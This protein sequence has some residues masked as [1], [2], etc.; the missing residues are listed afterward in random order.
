MT[1]REHKMEVI[2]SLCGGRCAP[3]AD[4]FKCLDNWLKQHGEDENA[5][6]TP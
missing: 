2:R 4:C 5:G 3:D 1:D 6:I